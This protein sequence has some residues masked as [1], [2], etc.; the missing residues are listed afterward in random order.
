M[1]FERD[2]FL[3]SMTSLFIFFIFFGGNL[4]RE[5]VCYPGAG[6]IIRPFFL[7]RAW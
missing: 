5:A 1:Y 3:S 7:E 2:S 4:G 6:L